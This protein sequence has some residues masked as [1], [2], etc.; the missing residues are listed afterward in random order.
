MFLKD[1]KKE[2]KNSGIQLNIEMLK[3]TKWKK[4]TQGRFS[5]GYRRTVIVP[6]I[7]LY[8]VVKPN[9]I[10][11]MKI[12]NILGPREERLKFIKNIN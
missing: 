10:I 6:A 3:K 2:V 5:A 12:G 1:Q 7:T 11:L 4:K 8:K 9:N